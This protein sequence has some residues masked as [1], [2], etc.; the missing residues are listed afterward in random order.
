MARNE[1][2]ERVATNGGAHSPNRAGSAY[3]GGQL[4]VATSLAHG[5]AHQGLPYGLLKFGASRQ[6]QR[7]GFETVASR[8]TLRPLA[9]KISLQQCFCLEDV[10][11][12]GFSHPSLGVGGMFL[13]LKPNAKQTFWTGR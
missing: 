8:L 4:A 5:N 7:Q 6:V 12:V 9:F 10:S 13:P 2:A 3:G 1:N 11:V